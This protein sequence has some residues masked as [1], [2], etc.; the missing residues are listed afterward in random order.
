MLRAEPWN[1]NHTTVQCEG[2]DDWEKNPENFDCITDM[3]GQ[4]SKDY[5][6]HPKSALVAE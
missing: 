6:K 2:E 5:H 3:H 1:L 4:V